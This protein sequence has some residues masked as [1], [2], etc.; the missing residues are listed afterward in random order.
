[1]IMRHVGVSIFLCY[2]AN[3]FASGTLINDKLSA[4]ADHGCHITEL[5]DLMRAL[6]IEFVLLAGA[7]PP[8]LGQV[9]ATSQSQE[10]ATK[11][12]YFLPTFDQADGQ[13]EV[14]CNTED[15]DTASIYSTSEPRTC[16]G[17]LKVRK[18][19]SWSP[20]IIPHVSPMVPHCM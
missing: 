2:L 15:V 6:E 7:V 11:P 10:L 17:T 18:L 9:Q 4:R 8:E 20:A 12:A 5:L 3:S 13:C 16:V 14:T 19:Y 1:M